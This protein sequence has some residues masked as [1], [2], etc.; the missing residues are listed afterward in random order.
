[1]SPTMLTQMHLLL[2]R[3]GFGLIGA[4]FFAMAVLEWFTAV[5]QLQHRVLDLHWLPATATWYG[6]P[7]GDGSDGTAVP[8]PYISLLCFLRFRVLRVCQDNGTA[9]FL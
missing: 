6:S 3:R 2:P 9:L 5:A 4:I 1:M 7:E 8:F